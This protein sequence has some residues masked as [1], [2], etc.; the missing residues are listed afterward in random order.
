MKSYWTENDG[1]ISAAR[2]FGERIGLSYD[3]FSKI[4]SKLQVG[5]PQ[6]L[7][8]TFDDVRE[9]QDLINQN[10]VSKVWPGPTIVLDE[11]TSRWT[12]TDSSRPTGP[13]ALTKMRGKP[14]PISHMI[15][16]AA[17]K[18]T[19]MIIRLELQEGKDAMAGKQFSDAMLPTTAVVRRLVHPW[20]GSGRN[21]V[22]DSWFTNKATVEKLLDVG[23]SFIGTVKIGKKGIPKDYFTGLQY[24]GRGDHKVLHSDIRGHRIIT[25][26]WNEP[27]MKPGSKKPGV[28]VFI[29]SAYSGAPDDPWVKDRSVLQA[30]GSII[31]R[32]IHVPMPQVVKK[33]YE[34]SNVIDVHNQYRQGLLAIERVW[35]THSWKLRLF[36]TYMGTLLVNAFL[37]YRYE[38]SGELTM[39]EFTEQVVVGL[40]E[41]AKLPEGEIG[42]AHV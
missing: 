8:K 9:F 36:Q 38:S 3:A 42:R 17:D 40:L 1:P 34:A 6:L 28:K 24:D 26:G 33:Y 31:K 29:A 25:V 10:L 30:D 22:A 27:G 11:G 4:R 23:L 2:R 16:T 18:D 32:E 39:R 14:E 41:A 19:G 21:V 20:I 12:G 7:R 35:A 15:K 5:P 37:G 13:P